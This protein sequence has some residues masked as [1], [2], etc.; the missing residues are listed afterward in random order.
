MGGVGKAFF[1][2]LMSTYSVLCV[3]G[4]SCRI[5]LSEASESLV[6]SPITVSPIFSTFTMRY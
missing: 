2:A 6:S 1:S 3:T 5:F 4:R